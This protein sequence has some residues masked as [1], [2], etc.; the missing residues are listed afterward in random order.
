M[1]LL[2]SIRVLAL[3]ILFPLFATSQNDT[4]ML[5]QT[6]NIGNITRE[7][8]LFVPDTTVNSPI[9]IL[10][11]G[12][13]NTSN[14]IIGLDTNGVYDSTIV[15]PYRPWLSIAK[16][17]NLILFIPNGYATDSTMGWN[18]CRGD[19][20]G[21]SEEDDVLFMRTTVDFLVNTYQADSTRVYANG[22]SNGGHMCIRL[23]QEAPEKIAAFA[24]IVASNAV[25]SECTHS[26]M[27]VSAL[28]MNGTSDPL[29]PYQ[30]GQMNGNRGEV[31][32]ADTTV[33]YWVMRNGTSTTPVTTNLPNTFT[34]DGCT[35]TKYEYK[36]GLNNTCVVFYKITSGGH[37]DPSAVQRYPFP[38]VPMALGNQNGDIEMA[39]EAWDFFK[40]KFKV[41]MN[42][43]EAPLLSKQP[44]VFPNPASSFFSIK[45]M[46]GVN[47]VFL[48]NS[49]GQRV[50][51]F[52]SELDSLD[53]SAFPPGI[54]YVMIDSEKGRKIEKLVISSR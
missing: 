10:L 23:A 36:N 45:N 5:N 24:S 52:G 48:L 49:F 38:L 22:T 51:E 32:P 42:T 7:Y 47:A 29:C 33:S 44:V 14:N 34:A 4:L 3:L 8:N 40:G 30:G 28:F 6:I 20:T 31:F 1:K 2:C 25:N 11:H 39:F 46:E 37:A 27:P 41:P 21:N 50:Y 16:K 43:K 12:Y 17:N 54:Y 15:A 13:G 53:V 26:T 9:V 35:V 19:A 18:D